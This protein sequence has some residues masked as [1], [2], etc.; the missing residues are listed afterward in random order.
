MDNEKKSTDQILH[1]IED[2]LEE[3]KGRDRRKSSA[4]EA[5]LNPSLER[6]KGNDRRTPDDN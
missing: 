4:T 5:Y 1:T 2:T 3:R 6:R